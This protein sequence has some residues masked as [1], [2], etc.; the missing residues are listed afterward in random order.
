MGLQR[1]E[2][3]LAQN[4]LEPIECIGRPFDPECMEVAHVVIEPG[5]QSTEVLEE[6]RRGYRWQ[7]RRFRPAQVRVAK[8]S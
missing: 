7:G 8:G 6:V 1:L 3:A 2:R 4:N 5:R